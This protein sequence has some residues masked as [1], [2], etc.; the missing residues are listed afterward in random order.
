MPSFVRKY[1]VTH[2]PPD[3]FEATLWGVT[4]EW[5]SQDQWAVCVRGWCLTAD[6]DLIHEP[7]PSSRSDE[8]IAATRLG[9][10][11]ALAMA[12]E[13]ADTMVVNGRTWRDVSATRPTTQG[14]MSAATPSVGGR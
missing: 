12:E 3:S 7:Q 2:L 14:C 1:L 4:V 5:R 9:L 10:D 8:F 11:T 6:G 13:Y